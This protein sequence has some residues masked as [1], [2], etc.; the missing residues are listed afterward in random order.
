MKTAIIIPARYGSTRFP[1]KPLALIGGQSMLGRVVA[2]ARSIAAE[3]DD[4]GV[5]ITTDDT[6][7]AN[8]AGEIGVEC[9][10]TS[11][12]CPSGSD[13]ALQAAK[14]LPDQ[15]DFIINLQGDAPF[16]PPDALRAVIDAFQK[17]ASLS[18]VTPV[19]ALSWDDLDRLRENKKATPFSGTCAILNASNNAIWFSKT[20]S[21]P[22][23]RKRLCAVKTALPPY[24]SIWD[25]TDL[26]SK[27]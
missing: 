26:I 19:H 4:C 22:S 7:I 14:Q 11:T 6:R 5:Y 17:D 21:P 1:G 24:S 3:F 9:L 2:L 13:R 20:S 23:A 12:D 8:H 15:P 25:Y 27:P 18:V 10:M 16:T